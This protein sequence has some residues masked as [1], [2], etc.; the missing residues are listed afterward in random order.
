MSDVAADNTARTKGELDL[1]VI[2]Q[3]TLH[4]ENTLNNR[5]N[6]FLVVE[7]LL[8]VLYAEI[9]S[10][11]AHLSVPLALAGLVMTLIWLV[12]SVRQGADLKYTAAAMRKAAPQI[13][14]IYHPVPKWL[15]TGALFLIVW[16]LPIIFLTI[17]TVLIS[18]TPADAVDAQDVAAK[19]ANLLTKGAT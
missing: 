9:S 19:A 13:V 15:K 10:T 16:G 11:R 18:A 14:E 6:I 2:V 7:S 4:E 12:T 1:N 3:L 17:W 5:V 8:L